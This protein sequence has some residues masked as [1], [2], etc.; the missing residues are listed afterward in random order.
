[1]VFQTGYN[2][3]MVTCYVI[4]SR[5]FN[6]F[7]TSLASTDI[8]VGWL[9]QSIKM[10]RLLTIKCNPKSGTLLAPSV[11][12]TW[13]T[14]NSYK[15]GFKKL[16]VTK[17]VSVYVYARFNAVRVLPDMYMYMSNAE[18]KIISVNV[19]MC[20]IQLLLLHFGFV[21]WQL[22]KYMTL[23]TWLICI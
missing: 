4:N 19:F 12:L 17:I 13:G 14:N 3:A 22:H 21:H 8:H 2:I 5:N 16:L 1:M 20:Q 11:A 9:Y 18:E 7:T 23:T 10:Q 6:L 15:C